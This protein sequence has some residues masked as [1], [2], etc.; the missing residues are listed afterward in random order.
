MERGQFAPLPERMRPR[1]LDEFVGQRHLVGKGRLLRRLMAEKRLLSLVLWGPPGTGKTT[2][3][4]LLADGAGARMVELSAVASGSKEL[5]EVF[6]AAEQERRLYGSPTVLFVDEIHRYSKTQQDV[7]LPAVE[8]GIVYLIGSTTENPRACLTR[9][10]LSRLQI[11]EL[12][13]LS[14]EDIEAAMAR[15]LADS[16]R[17]LGA[18]GARFADDAWRGLAQSAGGDLRRALSGLELSVL[19]AEEEDGVRQV[20]VEHVREAMRGSAGEFDES[21]LYDMLSAFGK[22][23]RGSDSD[24]ALYWFM[25]MVAAGV[26][27]RVPVRRL[28]VHAGEDVGMA[29]PQALQQAVAAMQALEFVGLPEARIPIAQAILFVCESPKSNSVV[30]ALAAVE[31]AIAL[32]PHAQVPA[33]LQDRTFAKDAHKGTM[34]VYPHDFPGHYVE[35]QYLP[36][37]LAGEVFY[38]PTEQGTEARVRPRKRRAGDGAAPP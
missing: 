1:T 36:D 12:Y 18:Y 32:H 5:R 30:T 3:A 31:E 27:P 11:C 4:R 9:A 26:D 14:G 34:Y 8:R 6:A 22:S 16:E 2:L 33:H 38:R 15:A 20:A 21:I 28:V 37:E 10:L 19:Y 29:S 24:A 35:Q 25:R 13:R 7:L 23:L 17:G